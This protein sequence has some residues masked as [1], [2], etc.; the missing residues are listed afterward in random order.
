MTGPQTKF[1]EACPIVQS[2]HMHSLIR[3]KRGRASDPLG[4]QVPCVMCLIII[5]C[6]RAALASHLPSVRRSGPHLLHL[7][8][9]GIMARTTMTRSSR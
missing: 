8:V 9:L 2:R 1:R 3:S 6:R 5:L 7:A 4:L